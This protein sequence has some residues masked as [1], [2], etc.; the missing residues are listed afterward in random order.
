MTH[1]A[2][3][4][5]GA[6]VGLIALAPA[7]SSV[8]ANHSA[9]PTANFA[10]VSDGIFRGAR[11]DQA[12]LETFAQRSYRTILDLEDDDEAIAQERAWAEPLGLNFIVES[13]SG[14]SNPGETQ[15]RQALAV[16]ADPSSRPIYVHC[17][18]GQDRT[19]AVIALHRVF[20]EGWSAR[21]AV[22]EMS[23]HGFNDALRT[24]KEYV[25]QKAGL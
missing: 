9:D 13:M 17:A 20:N 5:I 3:S 7:C 21:D 16:L 10:Q 22:A 18:K 8:P 1:K 25:E 12:A 2:T 19:G 23:A 4:I 14:M 24:L 6:L 15:M 11:P